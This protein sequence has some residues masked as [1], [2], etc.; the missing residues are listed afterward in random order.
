MKLE[1]ENSLVTGGDQGI[2]QA[3]ALKLAEVGA[4]VAAAPQAGYITGAT[5]VLDGGLL[6]S[7]SE[8]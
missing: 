7:Y 6:W 4:D 8:Q 1:G 5:I 2:G 3:A